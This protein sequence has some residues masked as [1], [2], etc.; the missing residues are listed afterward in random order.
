MSRGTVSQAKFKFRKND[1]IGAAAAEEDEYLSTCFVDTGDLALLED[2]SN[3]RI[4]VLGRTGSGKSALI[5]RLCERHSQ[6]AIEISPENL[7]LTYVSN[8]TIL[9]FFSDLG[10]NLDPF[11]K[12]LW[13]HIFTVE[14]LNR[15]FQHGDDQGTKN[16]I[17]RLRMRFPG[18]NRQDKEMKQAVDYLEKWGKTFWQDTEYRVKEV[19]V[20]VEKELSVKASAGLGI[21]AAKMTAS[22]EGAH[23]L[24]EE[25]KVELRKLGQ[26]VIAAAQVQDLHKV[27]K[28]L[29]SV[30]ADRQ[31]PYFIVIDKLDENWV[32]EKLRYKL[33]V[34]LIQAARDFSQIKNAK[35]ILALRR[36]LVDRVFRLMR[37]AGFQEEKYESLYLTLTWEKSQLIEILDRRVTALLVPRY[38]KGS[39]T[40]KDLLPSKVD[41]VPISKYL[42]DRAIRPRDIIAFF[43]ACIVAG[44]DLSRLQK[45]QFM[46]AE[47]AYSHLRL[48]ALGDE[49]SADYPA[50]L[51]TSK[52][53]R[54]RPTSF[55][56]SAVKDEDVADLCL[57]IAAEDP[58]GI[59][60]LQR[61]CIRVAEADLEPAMFKM[62]LVQIFYKVGLIGLKLDRQESA[63]WVAEAGRR[64]SITDIHQESS[65]LVH[66]MY[67]RALGIRPRR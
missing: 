44:T 26:D 18:N 4:I 53:L 22:G 64:V 34:A 38:T 47:R 2:P 33:I 10:V 61:E 19:T 7:A 46:E 16:L 30:L 56:L 60:I 45:K 62:Y 27:M 63:I 14:I 39:P 13:R 54:G 36:D 48:R 3:H 37:G 11:F 12:L 29:D 17:D 43:N 8:S 50:L 23:K 28:L 9:K 42:T 32:E 66:P 5:A 59:G 21:S 1:Q 52:L 31:K 25:K 35:V 6:Y 20:K 58:G 67:H 24:T 15:Y 65:V 57:T 55:K 41:N 51:D 49:W 40:H